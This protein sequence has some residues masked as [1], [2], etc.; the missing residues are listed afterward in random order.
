MIEKE[1]FEIALELCPRYEPSD[2]DLKGIWKAAINWYWNQ[3]PPAMIRY[4]EA[5]EDGWEEHD[6]IERLRYFLSL[7]LKPQ[8]WLDVEKFLDDLNTTKKHN[9]NDWKFNPD[10][11]ITNL[12]TGETYTSSNGY[13]WTMR[14]GK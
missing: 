10:G 8:D 14:S 11:S 3:S 9:P 2:E 13:E 12:Q 1:A 7:A 5:V 6:P 4:N